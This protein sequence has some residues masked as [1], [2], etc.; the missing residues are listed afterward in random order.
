MT[1]SVVSEASAA[2]ISDVYCRTDQLRR[3]IGT[4]VRAEIGDSA[5]VPTDRVA[6]G[7]TEE[8]MANR[9]HAQ[10]TIARVVCVP[11]WEL[12]EQQDHANRE[13]VLLPDVDVMA[14]VW[15]NAGARIGM[16]TLGLSASIRDLL[17]K[18]GFTPGKPI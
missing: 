12:F 16:H 11:S 4:Y 10:G 13:S 14:R 8:T 1:V 6:I 5:P 2:G 15:V 3:S 17:T 7:V 18:F 9:D